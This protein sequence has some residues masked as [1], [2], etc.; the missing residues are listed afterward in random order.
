MKLNYLFFAFF[1]LFSISAIAQNYTFTDGPSI[2][3]NRVI[4]VVDKNGEQ[5]VLDTIF[6]IYSNI[7]FNVATNN[8]KELFILDNSLYNSI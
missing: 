8:G 3:E 6:T 7:A 2:I 5:R 4:G 1:L